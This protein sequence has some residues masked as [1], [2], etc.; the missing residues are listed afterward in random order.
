[1][2]RLSCN[3]DVAVLG[4]HLQGH[5]LCPVVIGHIPEKHARQNDQEQ[6]K[7]PDRHKALFAP[8]HWLCFHGGL[9]S[10]LVLGQIGP[11][12]VAAPTGCG[13]SV[14]DGL[15]GAFVDAAHALITLCRP[16]WLV[17]PE[18][19]GMGRA[20]SRA[21]PAPVAAV[22]GKE[23][24]CASGKS[25]EPIIDEPGLDTCQSA[26]V[27]AVYRLPPLDFPGNPFQL[28]PGGGELSQNLALVIGIRADDVAVGHYQAIAAAQ[29]VQPGKLLHGKASVTAA[30]ANAEGKYL[31]SGQLFHKRPHDLRGTPG[32][33]RKD[34]AKL[35]GA[36]HIRQLF[37]GG[38]ITGRI[39]GETGQL[40]GCPRRVACSGKIENHRLRALPPL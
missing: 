8:G 34:K 28:R 26:F 4:H 6:E 16:D 32:V 40:P 20:V 35:L 10:L 31:G 15:L 25:V 13:L 17:L 19:N 2:V 18:G 33:D 37:Q 5:I 30:G 29:R 21:Q 9:T 12:G 3:R 36:V 39:P 23:G 7:D 38:D 11:D 1:M 27:D 24:L 14:L 22:P